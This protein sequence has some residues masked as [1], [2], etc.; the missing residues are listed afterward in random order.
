MLWAVQLEKC[1]HFVAVFFLFACVS[2][3]AVETTASYLVDTRGK[4]AGYVQL[5]TDLHLVPKFGVHRDILLLHPIPSCYGT[6]LSIGSTLSV[7]RF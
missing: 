2:T 3:P 6:Q 4:V 1:G 7:N 5:T